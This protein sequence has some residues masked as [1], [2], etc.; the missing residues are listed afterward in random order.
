M[1]IW[2]RRD[3][4]DP[5]VAVWGWRMLTHRTFDREA[6]RSACWVLGTVIAAGF[7]SCGRMAAPGRCRPGS[8]A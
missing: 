6:L 7:A 8:A 4:A 2:P 3:H 5:P 1:Q